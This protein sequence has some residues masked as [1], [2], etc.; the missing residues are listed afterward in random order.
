MHTEGGRGGAGSEDGGLQCA[1][2][3][4]VSSN[5][6]RF[7]HA[8]EQERGRLYLTWVKACKKSCG[9]EILTHFGWEEFSKLK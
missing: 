3:R 4:P 8:C 9:E 2:K 6:C 1:T 5:L 7:M